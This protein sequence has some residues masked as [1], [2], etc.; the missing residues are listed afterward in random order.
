[1]KLIVLYS[2]LVFNTCNFITLE[3]AESDHYKFKVIGF[4]CTIDHMSPTYYFKFLE[5]YDRNLK[6]KNYS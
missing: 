1:M 2:V 3:Q 4:D 5:H 6:V